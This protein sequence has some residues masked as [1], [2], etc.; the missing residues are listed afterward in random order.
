VIALSLALLLG[1]DPP[2]P[3]SKD[4]AKPAKK[5]SSLFKRK[6]ETDQKPKPAD[7][8]KPVVPDRPIPKPDAAKPENSAL[9]KE[10]IRQLGQDLDV[11]DT[12]DPL[13]RAGQRMRTVE[14]QFAKADVTDATA[15]L[16]DKIVA[17]LKVLVQKS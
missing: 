17:D 12:T 5:E 1:L 15:E 4:G 7:D 11:N 16:Q 2:Q 10:L 9:D 3:P 13:L 14:E 8:D 6:R